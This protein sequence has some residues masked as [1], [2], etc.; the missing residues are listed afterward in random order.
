LSFGYS[1]HGK[2]SLAGSHSGDLRFNV[3]HSHELALFAFTWGRELG[4][5]IEWIRPEVAGEQIA[6]QFFSRDEVATLRALPP[7]RQAEAFFNCWTRKEAYIKA[8]GEGLSLPLHLFDVSLAPG[9]PAALLRAAMS[10]ETTRWTMTALAPGAGYKAAL[11]AEG[12]DWHLRRWQW[13]D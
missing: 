8:R 4:V 9:E 12:R 3:S 7:G 11:V 1:E 6:E 2:P 10:D 13:P 5:D